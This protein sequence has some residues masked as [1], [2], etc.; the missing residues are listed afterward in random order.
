M[1]K[2]HP[3]APLKNRTLNAHINTHYNRSLKRKRKGMWCQNPVF[4]CQRRLKLRG[5]SILCPPSTL[6]Y[7]TLP[8]G[9]YRT[10]HDDTE[11]TTAGNVCIILPHRKMLS[12]IR[13]PLPHH[14][15]TNKKTTPGQNKK[16]RLGF[17]HLALVTGKIFAIFV[18]L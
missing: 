2:A 7:L 13:V 6:S 9:D 11:E 15:G 10:N 4:S 3:R 8:R 17:R 14:S 1:H 16:K 5:V 18:L 12:Y